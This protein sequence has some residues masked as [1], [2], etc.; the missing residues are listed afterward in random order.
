MYAVRERENATVY[1]LT[2]N[3]E[4]SADLYT[5][6]FAIASLRTFVVVVV[7]EEDDMARIS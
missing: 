3:G 6:F 1:H 2:T 5:F 4:S 7:V